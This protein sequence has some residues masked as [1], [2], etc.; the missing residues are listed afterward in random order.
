MF[1][2]CVPNIPDAASLD[3][4]TVGIAVTA[5]A[6]RAE[7]GPLHANYAG[8]WRIQVMSSIFYGSKQYESLHPSM[9]G[10]GLLRSARNM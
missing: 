6:R 3:E 4:I 2:C 10:G 5:H 7:C 9:Q 8:E 1:R